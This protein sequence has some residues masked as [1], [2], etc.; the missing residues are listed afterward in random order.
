MSELTPDWE[1]FPKDDID[2]CKAW[3]EKA[4]HCDLG[5]WTNRKLLA[6]VTEDW[7]EV[8]E[9]LET[10]SGVRRSVILTEA[11]NAASSVIPDAPAT[12]KIRPHMT[13]GQRGEIAGILHERLL[14]LGTPA[15]KPFHEEWLFAVLQIYASRA[16]HLYKNSKRSK[17]Y[18]ASNNKEDKLKQP[19]KPTSKP[20]HLKRSLE[21]MESTSRKLAKVGGV[22]SAYASQHKLH[23]PS[24]PGPTLELSIANSSATRL[25]AA[26]DPISSLMDMR[27]FVKIMPADDAM[28]IDGTS[29]YAIISMKTI[30]GEPKR[31]LPKESVEVLDISFDLF[32]DALSDIGGGFDLGRDSRNVLVWFGFRNDM[33]LK[34][35]SKQQFHNAILQSMAIK[36]NNV[37]KTLHW[38]ILRKED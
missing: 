2:Q 3:F 34:I 27:I 26:K 8:E 24:V 11:K 12:G 23:R 6:A 33:M 22:P 36:D 19:P 5:V 17:R 25:V 9:W 35:E 32:R 18:R 20:P 7:K 37:S 1:V 14:D 10:V 13:E 29:D 30:L 21:D 28:D 38:G 16:A 15:W 4:E 31:S